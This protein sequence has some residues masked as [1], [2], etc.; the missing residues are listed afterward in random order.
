MRLVVGKVGRAHGLTGEVVVEVRTDRPGERFA[1]GSALIAGP[2][3]RTLTVASARQHQGRLLVRFEGA[4]DRTAAES[5]RGIELVVESE[6]TAAPGGA[7]D[8]EEDA[9]YD[10]ELTGLRAVDPEGTAIG[11]VRE[12]QHLPAHDLLVVARE[13]APDA[14]V[15]FVA[16]IVPT[17]DL[18]A[19][20]VIIDDPGGLLDL[21]DSSKA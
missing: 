15:P 8:S 3:D 12:V 21:A 1:R 10:H 18:A 11:T 16:A 6:T 13:N 4:A 2:G 14:L 7:A 5:L 19:G 17:V 9:F 20:T